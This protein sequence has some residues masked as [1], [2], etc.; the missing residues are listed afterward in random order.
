LNKR[1][2]QVAVTVALAALLIWLVDWH[3]VIP[4]LKQVDRSWTVVILGLVVVE[5]LLLNFKWRGLL[6]VG[7]VHMGYWPL[8]RIQLAANALGIFLPG[9]IGV[10]AFRIAGL[11]HHRDRREQVVAATLFDRITTALATVVVGA[12]MVVLMAG[13]VLGSQAVTEVA[14]GGTVAIVIAIA[15]LSKRGKALMRRM[16]QW[17]PEKIRAR[18]LEVGSAGLLIAGHPSAIVLTI[19]TSLGAVA[20][21]VVI[22]KCLLL[23]CGVDIPLGTLAFILPLVWATTML[24]ISVGGIGVQDA[25]YVVLLGYAGVTSAV[26]IVVS[27]LDHILSRLP[28]AIGVLFWRDVMPGRDAVA[29][30]N[31]ATE[32]PKV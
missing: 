25:T 20:L 10:D 26:A 32:T 8:F 7:G 13:S 31:A 14:I 19:F 1:L 30:A 21:R 2:L 5:R 16:A 12:L 9:S 6:A 4:V 15:M 23:A 24:P 3:E 18:V 22:G 17:L 11:W 28:V 29:A 27:L